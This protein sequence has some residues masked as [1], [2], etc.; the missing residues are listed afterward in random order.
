MNWLYAPGDPL[1]QT[2]AAAGAIFAAVIAMTRWVGPRSFAKFTTYDFAFTVAIGSIISSTLTSA[3]SVARGCA[4]ILAL[5]IL[6]AVTAA[7]QRRVSWFSRAVNNRPLM[8]MNGADWLPENLAAARVSKD[9]VVAK[10]REA[11]VLNASQILA[12]VLESTGDI[13]V[14]HRPPDDSDTQLEDF[15]LQN[16]RRSP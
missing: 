9:Q 15:L 3:T 12:V 8:L 7:L 11:N 14:L 4:A 2:L 16:V 1:A 6:T 5:L 10:L 13:S